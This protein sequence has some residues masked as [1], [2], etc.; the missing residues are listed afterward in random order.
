MIKINK[1]KIEKTNKQKTKTNSINRIDFLLPT[2]EIKYQEA[3]G[4]SQTIYKESN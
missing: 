3:G 1:T 4:Y 2:S